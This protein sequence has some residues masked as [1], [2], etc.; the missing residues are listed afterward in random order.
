MTTDAAY[1]D[2]VRQVR[3]FLE[4][5]HRDLAEELRGRMEAA[6]GWM[7][8]E[9]A[10]ALHE[11]IKTVEEHG[12]KQKMATRRGRRTPT[13]SPTTPSLRWWR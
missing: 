2:A 1:A 6:S 8:Y 4:G 3:L 13:S 10:A 11:L 12:E 9:E 5:R 7:R